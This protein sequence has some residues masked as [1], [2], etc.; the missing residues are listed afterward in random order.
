MNITAKAI[1]GIA[2]T[3]QQSEAV[4]A[5]LVRSDAYARDSFQTIHQTV[6]SQALRHDAIG[7]CLG[8]NDSHRG[9]E[10]ACLSWDYQSKWADVVETWE[11]LV[12]NYG[13]PLPVAL[14]NRA[15]F[16]V[17]VSTY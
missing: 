3:R 8:R 15:A 11:R 9:W 16:W 6:I 2:L 13:F 10:K 1:F 17:G 5:W 7:V 12:E 4:G 14:A